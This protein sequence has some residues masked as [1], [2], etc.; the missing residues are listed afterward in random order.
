MQPISSGLKRASLQDTTE[1][2]EK[3]LF[4]LFTEMQQSPK[5]FKIKE[6]KRA[7]K[8]HVIEKVPKI[9]TVQIPAAS[10]LATINNMHKERLI[11]AV[12]GKNKKQKRQLERKLKALRQRIRKEKTRFVDDDEYSWLNSSDEDEY[13]MDDWRGKEIRSDGERVASLDS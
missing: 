11:D 7:G 6:F 4:A 12:Y 10:V 2:A 9:Q 8:R 3:D 1:N 5:L 13:N